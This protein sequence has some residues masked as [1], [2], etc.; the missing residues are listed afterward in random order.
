MKPNADRA[1]IAFQPDAAATVLL[2]GG[3]AGARA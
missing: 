2:S 3:T 1:S